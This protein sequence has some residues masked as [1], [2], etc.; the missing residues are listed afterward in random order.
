MFGM[1]TSTWDT[2]DWALTLF[3]VFLYIRAKHEEQRIKK[4][5]GF[6][7]QTKVAYG[8]QSSDIIALHCQ[9][10]QRPPLGVMLYV[11]VGTLRAEPSWTGQWINPNNQ[12]FTQRLF[13]YWIGNWKNET[14][15][16]KAG[17]IP[18]FTSDR[19]LYDR[20]CCAPACH[21][22]QSLF[23]AFGYKGLWKRRHMLGEEEPGAL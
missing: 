16:L 23:I 11:I 7:N 13:L 3:F 10:C 22:L 14:P 8:G 4:E 9:P 6:I 18:G 12:P 19:I 17:H 1:H 20:S 21:Y 5:R 15:V 2:C